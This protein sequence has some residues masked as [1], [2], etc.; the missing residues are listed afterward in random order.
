MEI[1]VEASICIL[2]YSQDTC[3]IYIAILTNLGQKWIV[4]FNMYATIMS[5]WVDKYRPRVLDHLDYHPMV[6]NQLKTL[7]RILIHIQDILNIGLG[8]R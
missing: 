3:I 4:Y 2:L 1:L 6:T 7:V 8:T 5:L